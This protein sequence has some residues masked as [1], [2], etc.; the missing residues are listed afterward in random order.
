MS[1]AVLVEASNVYTHKARVLSAGA[2]CSKG[3]DL[4]WRHFVPH[5]IRVSLS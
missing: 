5:A 3:S 1:A 4:V 2:E